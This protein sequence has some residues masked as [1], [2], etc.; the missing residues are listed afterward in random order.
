M[1]SQFGLCLGFFLVF[2]F[3]LRAQSAQVVW[4]TRHDLGT[5]QVEAGVV[6]DPAPA[7]GLV[8]PPGHYLMEISS[9]TE[10]ASLNGT[11]VTPLQWAPGGVLVR[12]DQTLQ[13]ASGWRMRPL[14]AADR[15]SPLLSQ[16]TL[17][18]AQAVLVEFHADV[19]T[20][21]ADAV[22]AE[23]GLVPEEVADLRP[24]HR[25]LLLLPGELQVLSERDEVAYLFPADREL[26][27]SVDH[28]ACPG[29][30]TDFGPIGQVVQTVGDGW[31]GPG[32]QA[33][34][35]NYVFSR[36][37]GKVSAILAQS[38]I[39]RALAEWARVAQLRFTRS[40]DGTGTRT[41][42]ILFGAGSHGDSYA[43]DGPGKVLA[44]TFYPA[45][46]NPESLAGD[47]HFDDDESW[48]IGADVDVYS[49]AL[50]ELGH[51]LGLG[52]SDKVGTVM[53]PYY[54]R[55]T[56]LTDEDITAI[57]GLY[58]ASSTTPPATPNPL[59]ITVRDIAAST[60]ATSIS[61]TGQVTGGQDPL[62]VTWR[63]DRGNSGTATGTRTWSFT[64]P[65]LAGDNNLTITAQDALSTSVTAVRQVTRIIPLPA[66]RITSP[67][68]GQPFTT[69]LNTVS[70]QGTSSSLAGIGQVT[71]TNG[72]PA[73]V[74]QGTTSWTASVPLV[75]GIN[76][77]DVTARAGDGQTAAQRIAITYFIPPDKTAPVLTLLTPAV[78]NVTTSNPT[79]TISGIARDNV[80][81]TEVSW[82]TSNGTQ[83]RASGT[84]T[85]S[86]GPVPLLVGNNTVMIRA[87]D[88]ARNTT[89]RTIT[90]LRR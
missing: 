36:M 49:V 4:K 37:T 14:L 42:N 41:I 23:L 25:L 11:P 27:T 66:I 76:N 15:L 69:T 43:F 55:A 22:L 71:W 54:R 84:A 67:N 53:Y 52:H 72:G 77:V 51:A 26:L 63:S 60:T 19:A 74:A 30:L 79:L 35:L 18:S 86:T 85:W 7:D 8:R 78:T 50:H 39:E 56:S 20:E 87:Y 21:L 59:Q 10:L 1:R 75:V 38:E 28:M 82:S 64:A 88:A 2:T 44:H 48:S 13:G 65:L 29:A 6:A 81:V 73:G 3:S 31:D 34:A 62:R 47:L 24:N 40:S 16:D 83:G 32:Q 57:R 89:W 9:E 90:V 80:A 61:L 33:A 5:S 12:A 17:D 58:A 68:N 46:P 45:P 70:L